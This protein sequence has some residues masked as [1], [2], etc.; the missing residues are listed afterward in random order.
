MAYIGTRLRKLRV[1]REMTQEQLANKASIARTDVNRIERDG[2][3]VG[4]DRL[5]RLAGALEVSV[6]ELAPEAEADP[7]GWTLLD[8]QEALEASFRELIGQVDRL[9]G[10]VEELMRRVQPG[11]KRSRASR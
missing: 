4:R 6:L 8:R 5:E 7:L 1:A 9:A 3:S 11:T 10:Q 2:L